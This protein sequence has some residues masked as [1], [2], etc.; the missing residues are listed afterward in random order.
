MK[1]VMQMIPIIAVAL[2][3]T[4]LSCKKAGTGPI[5]PQGEQ[6]LQGQQGA[7]GKDGTDGSKGD[8]G[9][10]GTANVIY[11]DWMNTSLWIA[12]TTS[13]GVGKKTY[14]F[15]ISVPKLSEEILDKG[16]VL[17]Y[18]KFLADP[19]STGIIKALPSVYYNLGGT[20]AEYRFQYGLFINRIRIVCDILPNG[21]PST[22]NQ[23]RYVIIPGGVSTE[24]VAKPQYTTLLEEYN[25]PKMGSNIQP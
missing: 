4:I 2:T 9:D 16:T 11:S 20:S 24:L 19:D 25:I 12:S 21:S 22:S 3:T 14:Y 23:V 15:D 1:K 8:K 7:D 5:G 6:G 13:T 17:V 10:A 18:A